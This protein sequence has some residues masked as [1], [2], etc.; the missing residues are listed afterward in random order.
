MGGEYPITIHVA[1]AIKL[2]STYNQST[3]K[4]LSANL[5][6]SFYNQMMFPLSTSDLNKQMIMLLEDIL[7]MLYS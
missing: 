1:L 3:K 7:F 5:L 2:Y 4:V 6:I